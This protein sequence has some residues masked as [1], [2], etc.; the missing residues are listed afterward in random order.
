MIGIYSMPTKLFNNILN[1]KIMKRHLLSRELNI[2]IVTILKC[3]NDM[4]E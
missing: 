1:T 4:N 2:V 3:I